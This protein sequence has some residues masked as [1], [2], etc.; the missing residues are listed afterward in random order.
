MSDGAKGSPRRGEKTVGNPPRQPA[1]T[2]LLAG[3]VRSGSPAP[4]RPT[5]GSPP[6]SLL[7]ALDLL[8]PDYYFG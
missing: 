6:L 8:P 2:S 4:S 1:M 3:L 7:A 5:G